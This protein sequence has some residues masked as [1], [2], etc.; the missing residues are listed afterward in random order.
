ME[1]ASEY[2]DYYAQ[3]WNAKPELSWAGLARVVGGQ[4]V[5]G[6]SDAQ[7]G[8]ALLPDFV[9]VGFWFGDADGND[10]KAFQLELFRGG[11]KIFKDIGWQHYAYSASGVAALQHVFDTQGAQIIIPELVLDGWKLIDEGE[12]ENNGDKILSG[13]LE[14]ARYEQ[15]VVIVETYT[16]LNEIG[17]GFLAN[18]MSVLAKNPVQGGENLVRQN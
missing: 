9:D 14:I 2:Y 12:R 6:N 15:N 1:R 4:V 18:A 5:A 16:Q 13:S 8:I 3:A 17:D 7:W 10:L 11:E